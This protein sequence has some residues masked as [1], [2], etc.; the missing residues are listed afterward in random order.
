MV[1]YSYGI[2]GMIVAH[3]LAMLFASLSEASTFSL[4][5][6]LHRHDYLN[7]TRPLMYLWHLGTCTYILWTDDIHFHECKDI[8]LLICDCHRNRCEDRSDNWYLQ[9]WHRYPQC[10]HGRTFQSRHGLHWR[11][12][13]LQGTVS[14]TSPLYVEQSL[15]KVFLCHIGHD[16]PIVSEISKHRLQLYDSICSVWNFRT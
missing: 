8:R 16:G 4:F 11:R 10:H 14:T 5:R 2:D 15:R 1:S 9:R 6:I 12:R 13:G 7:S 3:N